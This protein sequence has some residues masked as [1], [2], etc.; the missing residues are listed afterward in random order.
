[1]KTAMQELIEW[2]DSVPNEVAQK[3]FFIKA[4][5]LL[6]KEK[7]QI[8]DAYNTGLIEGTDPETP[9]IEA[10]DYYNDKFNDSHKQ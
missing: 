1:M 8:I 10:E 7:Q 9:E 3:T 5:R 6:G 4:N 2:Y